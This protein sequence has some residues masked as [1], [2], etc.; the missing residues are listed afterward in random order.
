MATVQIKGDQ[1]KSSTI[2]ASKLDLSDNFTFTGD[3]QVP[4]T[5]ANSSSAVPKSYVLDLVQG[6]SYKDP[7]RVSDQSSISATYNNTAKTLTADQNGAFDIDSISNPQVGDRI[8]I[9]QFSSSDAVANG[10]YELTTVGDASNPYVL[11]RSADMNEA[12]EFRNAT[13]FVSEGTDAD[14]LFTQQ[15]DNPTLGTSQILFVQISGAAGITAGDGLAKNGNTLSVNVDRGLQIISDN[16]EAR[17]GDGIEFDTANNNEMR[18]KL[19]GSSLS[20]S[21]SGL[22]IASSGVDTIHLAPSS[23]TS[24]KIN[25]SIAGNG[26]QGG[27]GSALSVQADQGI[28]VGVSGVT[29]QLD[30]TTLAKSV[31][32]LKVNQITSAEIQNNAVTE[33]K[34]SSAVAGDGLAGGSGSAL[35]VDLAVNPALQFS[36]NK[37]DLK[38][39]STGSGLQKDANGLSIHLDGTT[40]SYSAT[41]LKVAQVGTT[42]LQNNAVTESK[43]SSAVAGQGLTGGAGS[44]LAV[45]LKPSASGLE[46][47]SDQLGL[48][49]DTTSGLNIDNTSGLQVK[50]ETDGALAFDLTNGGLEVQVDGGTLEIGTNQLRIK[51]AGIITQKIA[52]DQITLAKLKYRE[53]FES[54]AGNG[55]AT[56][57]DLQYQVPADWTKSVKVFR[58]GLRLKYVASNPADVD[59]YSVSGNGGTGSVCR[60]TI[61]SAPASTD[62]I[63]VDYK[64]DV[65]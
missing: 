24:A 38:L 44:S 19:D 55:S 32:G 22:A 45:D 40:L 36:S 8:L 29:I 37:L 15:T 1:I 47:V 13:V 12:D 27:G 6:L 39:V 41:G 42:E 26:L 49:V 28:S 18:I 10:I 52:D 57:F 61:G 9:R 21:S 43:I 7:V 25:S 35:S 5:P 14:V 30:G 54:F 63:F 51:D 65:S 33:S 16:L 23:V 4:S 11:T 3:V 56:T 62:S 20:R 58:N 17:I 46:F 31:S 53:E 59:Q 2:E 60:I 34:I 64:Y 50:V 48:D